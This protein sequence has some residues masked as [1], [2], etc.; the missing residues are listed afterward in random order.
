M[1]N[2]QAATWLCC[3]LFHPWSLHSNE[4]VLTHPTHASSHTAHKAQLKPTNLFK[5]APKTTSAAPTKHSSA[6]TFVPRA[7]A[8][9]RPA[10]STPAAAPSPTHHAAAASA[11]RTH[12][13]M[14][15]QTR[16]R[17]TQHAHDDTHKKRNC[18]ASQESVDHHQTTQQLEQER[19]QIR[20]EQEIFDDF[21]RIRHNAY[22]DHEQH[23]T[24][25][26][27]WGDR[28]PITQPLFEYLGWRENT[29][30]IEERIQ[31]QAEHQAQRTA[32]QEM[33]QRMLAICCAASNK[34]KEQTLQFFIDSSMNCDFLDDHKDATPKNDNALYKKNNASP[35]QQE[36][37][38][39]TRTQRLDDVMHE[40][41]KCKQYAFIDNQGNVIGGYVESYDGQRGM[42]I[43]NAE[44]FAPQTPS[45]SVQKMQEFSAHHS[46]SVQNMKMSALRNTPH[47]QRAN[48][49]AAY[50]QGRITGE[51]AGKAYQEIQKYE[52]LRAAQAAVK[53]YEKAHNPGFFRK[54]INYCSGKS[55]TPPTTQTHSAHTPARTPQQNNSSSTPAQQSHP[56]PTPITSPTP[57]TTPAHDAHNQ[58]LNTA[59]TQPTTAQTTPSASLTQHDTN[60]RQ[61]ASDASSTPSPAQ[62][63]SQAQT[64]VAATIC[65][66]THQP[67]KSSKISP[68]ESNIPR[69]QL[70]AQQE[71][72]MHRYAPAHSTPHHDQKMLNRLHNVIAQAGND[73]TLELAQSGLRSWQQ[74]YDA[75][76]SHE[77]A[78]YLK[79]FR[80]FYHALEHTTPTQSIAQ[81]AAALKQSHLQEL[82]QEYRDTLTAYKQEAYDHGDAIEQDPHYLR[83]HKRAQAL[84]ESAS[85]TTTSKLPHRT[86]QVS[87]QT[88]QFMME[89]NLNYAAF[90][91]AKVTNF[92]DCLT[93]EI[94]SIVEHAATIAQH[95]RAAGH[96]KQ[97]AVHN[98]NLAISAQQLNQA[99]MVKQ[100]AAV[101]D[102]SHFFDTY[103]QF[104]ADD[105][106]EYQF[107]KDVQMGMVDGTVHAL[108]KWGKFLY[109]L[110]SQPRQT[111]A[112]IAQDCKAIG[113][114]VY[115]IVDTACQFM[116]QA[117]LSDMNQ[118]FLERF[119][120]LNTTHDGT[121][122]TN[123]GPSY[124]RMAQRSLRNAQTLKI[125]AHYA[126]QAAQKVIT[127]MMEQS[128]RQNVASCTELLVDNLLTS[129]ATDC[130]LQ[131]A[132][133]IGMPIA[134]AAEQLTHNIPPHL[135]DATPTFM[136]SAGKTIAMAETGE[137][138]S[139]AIT[140]QVAHNNAQQFIKNSVRAK[141]LNEK[142]QQATKTNPQKNAHKD[143]YQKQLQEVTSATHIKSTDRLKKI[144]ADIPQVEEFRKYTNDFKNLEILKPEEIMYLNLCDWLEPQARAINAEIKAMGGIKIIDPVS[145][146]E[147]IIEK[148]DLVHSLLGEMKPGSI[149]HHTSGGHAMISELR[150]A[151]LDIGKIQSLGNGFLD[152]EIQ[153]AGKNPNNFALKTY[154]PKDNTIQECVETITT[155]ISQAKNNNQLIKSCEFFTRTNG[156]CT[157]IELL[158]ESQQGFKLYIEN[159]IAKFFPLNTKVQ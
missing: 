19:C 8:L 159:N 104:L 128:L 4:A 133:R 45:P 58:Q 105:A 53:A 27:Q 66:Q 75:T 121:A 49:D 79:K 39:P 130:L 69:R 37:F 103:L 122:I 137:N 11:T 56:A 40:G 94:L 68:E 17:T 57:H 139:A 111:I 125:G 119:H 89:H 21:I 3:L 47:Y 144:S 117:Y 24:R 23:A 86:Y 85:Q 149:R 99:S 108:Q 91:G 109:K 157:S 35:H 158:N 16:K 20:Q 18:T 34:R 129:K 38:H 54:I 116:P 65:K 76:S 33:K 87:K 43:A 31:V 114:C 82:L 72:W 51:Q 110:G 123:S 80:N 61:T 92:Q 127:S 48:I 71:S 70:L 150:A 106:S 44:N 13:S 15:H 134:Q 6:S 41:E 42:L 73:A 145:K 90:D 50:N 131:V 118:D 142:I 124:S 46:N 146:T 1:F 67:S 9:A 30:V 10:V 14:S 155:A 107:V 84:A 97:L 26:A 143:A 12:Q 81:Q 100:A 29:Q 120:A 88:R 93:Q 148:F 135:Q 36:Q 102:Y 96:I 98:C 32:C 140:T 153:Y 132:T 28:F 136:T 141:A 154:F 74:A 22:T 62:P 83:L 77:R 5:S 59:A 78:H 52:Q 2:L 25:P 101:T 156:T 126:L 95:H 60:I 147:V 112:D 63:L 138:I 7:Q 64:A 113:Q 151:S 55:S 152:I 115:T